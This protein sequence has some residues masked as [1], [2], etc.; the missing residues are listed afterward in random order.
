MDRD[1]RTSERPAALPK[2][3]AS[4]PRTFTAYTVILVTV[5][6]P[7]HLRADDVKPNPTASSSKAAVAPAQSIA[8]FD[9]RIVGPDGKPIPD[10]QVEL[11]SEPY[12]LTD[13]FRSGKLLSRSRGGMILQADAGGRLVFQRP[14]HLDRLDIFIEMPGYAPYWGGMGSQDEFRAN[15]RGIHRQ[16]AGRLVRG[17]DRRRR[18]GKTNP[19]RAGLGQQ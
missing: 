17:R 3:S 16:V 9:L 19:G 12:L 5:V 14:A 1:L 4:K 6:A 7:S 2:R 15:P 18:H 10:A 13:Q 8:T 11:R